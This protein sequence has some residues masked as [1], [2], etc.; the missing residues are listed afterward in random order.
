[1]EIFAERKKKI[2]RGAQL[3]SGKRL[4]LS[5]SPIS[6]DRAFCAVKDDTFADL[7]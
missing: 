1:M 5:S 7:S 6:Q 3:Y 4:L 2:F